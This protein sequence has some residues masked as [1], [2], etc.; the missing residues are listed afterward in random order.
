M[1]IIGGGIYALATQIQYPLNLLGI[2][3]AITIGAASLCLLR[4]GAVIG[5]S[6]GGHYAYPAAPLQLEEYYQ[7]LRNHYRKRDRVER[8]FRNFLTAEF[9][10]CSN[11][12]SLLNDEKAQRLSIAKIWILWSSLALFLTGSLNVANQL[13]D[14]K[15]GTPPSISIRIEGPLVS[16][17]D[18]DKSTPE[19]QPTD[20]S[21]PPEPPPGRFIKEDKLPE[22]K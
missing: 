18:Q 16:N 21:N 3:Q 22:K 11:H 12:N 17:Q 13:I 19:P 14:R 2:L 4:A 10:R 1:A 8:R 7:N 20:N 5:R 6:F 9:I 15:I